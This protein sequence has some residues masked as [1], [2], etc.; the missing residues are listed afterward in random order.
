LR[1]TGQIID[2]DSGTHLWADRFDGAL[3]DVFTLQDAVAE[4]VIAA[5]VPSRPRSSEPRASQRKISALTTA[6]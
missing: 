5:L 6:T 1:I 3:E 4:K 2:S